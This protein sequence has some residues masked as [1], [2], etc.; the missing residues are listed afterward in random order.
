MAVMRNTPP[1]VA[2][3]ES[4]VDTEDY[5]TV[6]PLSLPAPCEARTLGRA[7]AHAVD[8]PGS[9]SEG[10]DAGAAA[11]HCSARNSTRMPQSDASFYSRRGSGASIHQRGSAD[12]G[13]LDGP[14]CI[15]LDELPSA[16]AVL[17]RTCTTYNNTDAHVHART[18]MVPHGALLECAEETDVAS[19]PSSG[20]MLE[21]GPT[22]YNNK[23]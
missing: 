15:S 17:H 2:R 4:C 6:L 21:R 18:A 1:S 5:L 11:S 19:L 3:P 22:V 14:A 20:E 13:M 7:L 16:N 8:D 9:D 23:R 10:E 12:V